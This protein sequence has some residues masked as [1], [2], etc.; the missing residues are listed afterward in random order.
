MTGQIRSHVSDM[1]RWDIGAEIVPTSALPLGHA[2]RVKTKTSDE[3][4][5]LC[6]E[7][8]RRSSTHHLAQELKPEK[9]A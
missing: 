8:E 6:P 9:L 7:R 5:S 3:R 2:L 1:A 4:L